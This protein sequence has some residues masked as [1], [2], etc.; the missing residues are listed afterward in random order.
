[1]SKKNILND[2]DAMADMRK[3]REMERLETENEQL[4]SEL[5]KKNELLDANEKIYQPMISD[6]IKKLEAELQNMTYERD[7]WCD[8]FRRAEA[9]NYCKICGNELNDFKPRNAKA[10][11]VMKYYY[12]DDGSWEIDSIFWSS[13]K[14]YQQMK[15][16]D[17]SDKRCA[18][19]KKV[20][21]L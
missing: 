6:G 2:L 9:Q 4:K 10:Y 18:Y 11:A 17:L 14:A 8:D 13:D 16:I 12:E 5:R 3:Q 21:V 1:M 19:V 7:R 15:E 20:E